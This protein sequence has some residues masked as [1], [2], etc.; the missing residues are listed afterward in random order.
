MIWVRE[1]TETKDMVDYPIRVGSGSWPHFSTDARFLALMNWD[2][3]IHRI[4]RT[5]AYGSI[6]LSREILLS[7]YVFLYSFR[8][9]I[10]LQYCVFTQQSYQ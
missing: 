9:N 7:K 2:Q 5:V 1:D 10:S 8:K 6:K 3:R 4:P